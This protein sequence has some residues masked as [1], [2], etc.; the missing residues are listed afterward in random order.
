DFDDYAKSVCAALKQAG[1]R[2]S[3]ELGDSRLNAKVRA[4]QTRK[5]PYMLVVGEREAREAEVA[6]RLRDGRQLPAM[7]LADF[8]T[9]LKEKIESKSLDL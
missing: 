2:V 6:V 5:I 9:Y 7:K 8:T 3:A 4:C 1:L